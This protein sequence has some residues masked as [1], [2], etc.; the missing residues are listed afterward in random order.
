MITPHG[1]KL[2]NLYCSIERR[3]EILAQVDQ[4]SKI[5][6]DEKNLSDLELLANGAFSPL[7]GFMKRDEYE[8]VVN[9]MY[10]SVG[11]PWTIPITL[12]VRKSTIAQIS[13]QSELLLINQEEYPL[14]ILH[15]EDIFQY[16][17]Y[18]EAR[19]VFGTEDDKHPG[20]QYLYQQGEY[21]LGGGN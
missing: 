10:F 17:K 3:A 12:A 6:L 19:K 4:Y 16:D 15:L 21:Y 2:I 11:I 1:G 13:N 20:V 7:S 9:H 18:E 14:A 5:I 8:S